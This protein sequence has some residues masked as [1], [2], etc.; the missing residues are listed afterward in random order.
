MCHYIYHIYQYQLYIWYICISY[1]ILMAFLFIGS[2]HSPHPLHAHWICVFCLLMH[3]SCSVSSLLFISKFRLVKWKFFGVFIRQTY[4]R[5]INEKHLISIWL[6]VDLFCG[7]VR[8]YSKRKTD[9]RTQQEPVWCLFHSENLCYSAILFCV[10]FQFVFWDC[11]LLFI[12][13]IWSEFSI[14][15]FRYFIQSS[16]IF[17]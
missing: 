10:F 11:V 13:K 1:A 17:L 8:A 9:H 7:S 4:S 2:L 3:N 6:S 14:R 5:K 16:A 12:G 15:Y